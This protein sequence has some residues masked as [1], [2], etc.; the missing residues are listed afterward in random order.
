MKKSTL[1]ALAV[2]TALSTSQSFAADT[3]NYFGVS[4][5][6]TTVDTGVTAGSAILDDEDTGFK[7]FAGHNLNDSMAI[8]VHYADLGEATLSGNSG[9]TFSIS[10]TAYAFT[11]NNA[12]VAVAATSIGAAG[13]YKFTTNSSVVPF[14][15]LGLHRWEIDATV[16]GG[17]SFASA[18]DDGVDIF[19]G[20]GADVAVNEKISIRAE[21][22]SYDVDGDDVDNI[23][24]GLVANF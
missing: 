21:Y 5:G 16:S 12:K 18:T 19:F 17:S 22:E 7:I 13:V 3:S 1:I 24:I 20:F 10:G 11:V 23:S 9:D 15:K 6:Q 4:Y 8:E 2:T 14:A